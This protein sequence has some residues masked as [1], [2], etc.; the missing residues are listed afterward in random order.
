MIH[1]F[2]SE[3]K[4]QTGGLMIFLIFQSILSAAQTSPLYTQQKIKNYLP[5][6]TTEEVSLLLKKSDMV[7][8]PV[9]ALEQHANH[10]PIG[11][12]FLNGVEICKLIA[13]DRDLLVAPVL[14]AGQSPYHMGFAGTITLSAETIVK[15]HLETVQSLIK[16]GF[17]RFIF[18]TAH[19]GNTAIVQFIIDQVNQTTSGV[20]VNYSEAM[21]P[22]LEPS[23]PN[24]SKELN[25]HGGTGETSHLMYLLP[26]LVNL[27]KATEATLTLPKHL[28]AMLPNVN[29]DPTTSLLFFA[30]ALKAEST[31]KKTSSSE[32]S[33]TGV[34]GTVNPNLSTAKMGEESVQRQVKAITKFIDKWNELAA[35]K[36]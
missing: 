24:S 13:Q 25:R 23:K 9:A 11:T 28:E 15:V 10:L 19:S 33:S 16:H 8:I 32:I 21:Q 1:F 5:H 31:G 12:D 26:G 20:A 3:M 4:I 29:S 17:K 34:L 6:M 7:I 22:F 18:M 30:E 2:N 27:Q 36:Q 14:M 35:K